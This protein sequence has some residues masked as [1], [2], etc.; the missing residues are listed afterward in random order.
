MHDFLDFAQQRPA[1]S[2]VLFYIIFCLGA[3][4][5]QTVALKGLFKLKFKSWLLFILYPSLE[6][7]LFFVY[8]PLCMPLMI[9]LFIA[10]FPIVF[11]GIVY[12]GTKERMDNHKAEKQFNLK[13]NIKPKP[14]WKKILAIIGSLLFSVAFFA[15]GPTMIIF[16]FIIIPV[17]S[18]LLPSNRKRFYNFQHILPTSKIRS[19]AMGLAEI[20]G[21]LLMDTP[22]ISPI[23][24]KPCIGYHYKIEAV[25]TDKDGKDSYSTI[26]S[27]TEINP[28]RVKDETGEIEVLPENLELIGVDIDERYT[29]SRKR[30]TQYLL[31]E[32]DTML[33]VGSAGLK[34][35]NQ[36]VFQKDTIKNVFAIS[37]T[38]KVNMYNKYKPLMNSGL[39][40]LSYFAFITALILITPIS[41]KND[42]ITVEQP[43]FIVKMKALL[44]K[45]DE[46]QDL[47]PNETQA[48]FYYKSEINLDTL[49]LAPPPKAASPSTSIKHTKP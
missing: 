7:L 1:F 10:T 46:Q 35:H 4:L 45:N 43:E 16:L 36:P 21:E 3:A 11:I 9:F 27:E 12:G 26:F 18:A 20:E 24:S 13:H 44:F 42:K 19:L 32:N 33:L 48:P 38:H 2:E 25:K 49:E 39:K 5:F 47:S 28:F 40:Y 22:K 29:S 37:P 15:F 8:S 31:K 17:A 30:Y 34:A 23:G 41:L 6:I 14:T